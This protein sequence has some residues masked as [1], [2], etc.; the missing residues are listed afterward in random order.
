MASCNLCHF[1]S[2]QKIFKTYLISLP[3]WHRW[4]AYWPDVGVLCEVA[5]PPDVEQG[6]VVGG[7]DEAQCQVT[8]VQH[9]P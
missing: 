2:R 4:P 9:H 7:D 3:R 6:E 5:R 8:W 1:K